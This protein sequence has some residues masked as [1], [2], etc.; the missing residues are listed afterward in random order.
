MFTSAE[1]GLLLMNTQA[2]GPGLAP[3]PWRMGRDTQHGNTLLSR[4]VAE[5]AAGQGWQVVDILREPL[6]YDYLRQ[7]EISILYVHGINPEFSANEILDIKRFV[8]NGGGLL[9]HAD[10]RTGYYAYKVLRAFGANVTEYDH[11]S[12]EL[13]DV[14]VESTHPLMANV[15]VVRLLPAYVLAGVFSDGAVALELE[16]PAYSILKAGAAEPYAPFVAAA[17]VGMGRVV[18]VPHR[19]AVDKADNATFYRNALYWLQQENP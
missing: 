13:L 1:A 16:Y 15:G 12:R 17:E 4:F 8:E 3:R 11:G 14:T 9:I 5:Y 2:I 10:P 7:E 19:F 6:T 18:I